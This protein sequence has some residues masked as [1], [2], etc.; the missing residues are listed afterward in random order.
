M[1]QEKEK[2]QKKEKPVTCI[3]YKPA[4]IEQHIYIT[5]QQLGK[6]VRKKAGEVKTFVRSKL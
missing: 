3:F 6:T 2:E 1:T 5:K 4:H